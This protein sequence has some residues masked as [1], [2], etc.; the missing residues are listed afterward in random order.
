MMYIADLGFSYA[1]DQTN[2]VFSHF[3]ATLPRILPAGILAIMGPSGCGKTTLL[4]LLGG[5]ETL[6]SGSLDLEMIGHASWVF[7]E[8]RL[9]PWLNV[10]QNILTTV[11]TVDKQIL[12]AMHQHAIMLGIESNLKVFPQEL[13]GGMKS[14]VAILR[15]LLHE[16][17]SYIWDE[18]F[19]A[20]DQ[21]N[22]RRIALECRE[23]FLQRQNFVV[24]SFHD[25]QDALR[26][27][28]TILVLPA[29]TGASAQV[30][31]NFLTKAERATET[32]S[33]KTALANLSTL[34][35][36]KTAHTYL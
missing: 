5:L 11:R 9:L 25:P 19:S 29:E 4:R 7:Q 12:S 13:S 14:R 17:P 33:F 30:Y 20:L 32:K 27:S 1:G 36:P 26:F 21:D 34:I 6:Q 2:T 35:L 24:A 31:E 22:R 15:S 3:S 23:F 16:A 10:S 8:D 18:P 28:D